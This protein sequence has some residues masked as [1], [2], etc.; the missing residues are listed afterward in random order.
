MYGLEPRED[1]PFQNDSKM[2]DFI[3]RRIQRLTT[4]YPSRWQPLTGG[5]KSRSKCLG[6]PDSSCRSHERAHPLS[7]GTSE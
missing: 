3:T 6:G 4:L 2:M 5:R 1:A 7:G